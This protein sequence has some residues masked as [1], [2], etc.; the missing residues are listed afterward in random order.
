M[1]AGEFIRATG[2][3]LDPS[4]LDPNAAGLPA[5]FKLPKLDFNKLQQK[6]DK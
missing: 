5:G 2:P 1:W 4:L 3:G 6:R